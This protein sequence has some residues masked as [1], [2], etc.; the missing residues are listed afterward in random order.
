MFEVDPGLVKISSSIVPLGLSRGEFV[1]QL[2]FLEKT[3]AGQNPG[4]IRRSIFDE[5]VVILCIHTSVRLD[6]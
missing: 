2:L 6:T 5:F 3:V 1:V 4:Y